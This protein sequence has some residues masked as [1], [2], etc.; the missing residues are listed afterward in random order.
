MDDAMRRAKGVSAQVGPANMVS[1]GT[2]GP[3]TIT[4]NFDGAVTRCQVHPH[5]RRRLGGGELGTAVVDTVHEA[6]LL[7]LE[8]RATRGS[9]GP[10]RPKPKPPEPVDPVEL[11]SYL[12]RAAHELSTVEG[13]GGAVVAT[14]RAGRLIRLDLRPAWLRWTGHAEIG[15][16]LTEVLARALPGSTKRM[17]GPR[18]PLD[19]PAQLLADLG[20]RKDVSGRHA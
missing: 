1:A 5:W 7:M 3:V 18:E 13:A 6:H 16:V 10:A 8:Q 14:V 19:D 4:M 17:S 2:N 11:T 15:R 20:L 12:M 9:N